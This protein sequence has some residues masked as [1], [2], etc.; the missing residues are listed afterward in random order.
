[1]G[2]CVS[3]NVEEKVKQVDPN[4]ITEEK[5]LEMDYKEMFKPFTMSALSRHLTEEIW[6]EYKH[7]DD[8][9]TVP[10]TKVVISGIRNQ[11]VAIGVYATSHKCYR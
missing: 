9:Y 10:F 11:Q 4:L 7:Q 8:K 5:L 3:T 1:M 6:E 2:N